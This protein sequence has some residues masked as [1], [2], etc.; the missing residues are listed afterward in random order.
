MLTL[1]VGYT[2]REVVFITYFCIH[3]A[4]YSSLVLIIVDD[5]RKR[6]VDSV[7]TVYPMAKKR[8]LRNADD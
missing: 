2:L 1:I 5:K 8:R 3:R 7:E 4:K 6:G